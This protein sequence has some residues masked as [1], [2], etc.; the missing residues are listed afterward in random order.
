MTGQDAQKILGKPVFG[1][2]EHIAARN[3]LRLVADVQTGRDNYQDSD[4]SDELVIAGNPLEMTERQLS[5]E[6]DF[7]AECG[8]LEYQ[9]D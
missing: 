9:D 3:P 7:W 6:L 5:E 1:A 2:E 8:Y 4:E